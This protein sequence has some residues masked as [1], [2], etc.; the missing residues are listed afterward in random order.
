MNKKLSLRTIF[1]P[2]GA[3]AGFYSVQVL[4]TVIYVS[5]LSIFSELG[6]N[7]GFN[8]DVAD[9]QSLIISHSNYISAIYST[10]IIII[11]LVVFN[12]L[13]KKDRNTLIKT[14]PSVSHLLV[15][16]L[17]MSGVA[18]L[19]N[20]QLV[21]I[22][23]LG[24]VFPKIEEL[25]QNYIELSEAFTG[26]G[27]IAMIILATCILVPI[28]EELVF[29]G[30]IQ[31]ELRRAFP[32]WAAILIQ[33]LIFALVHGNPIQISYVLLPAL[34]LGIVYEWTKSIYIPIA[35]HMFFNFIGAA[36]PEILNYNE[37]AMLYLSIIQFALIP[38][39]IIALFY[40]KLIRINYDVDEEKGFVQL[41]DQTYATNEGIEW[42]HKDL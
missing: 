13:N 16:L 38:V 39:G 4:V 24:E 8:F 30:I 35:L 25:L 33:M 15:S 26:D 14:K 6:I 41:P 28:A 40:L 18:G 7:F 11:A 22:S 19:I 34:V 20:L 5:I 31:G 23:A 3:I 32:A 17:V 29:R 12:F 21:G 37:T 27:N 10:I 36:L 1:I 42:V 9:M 2:I